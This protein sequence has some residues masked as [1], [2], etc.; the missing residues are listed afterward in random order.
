VGGWGL[1]TGPTK[2]SALA[3]IVVTRPVGREAELV[4][5]LR[6]LGHD[7]V[8]VPLVAIEP[9]GNEPVDVEAYDWVVVTSVVGARELRRR[10][11]G[12][13]RH[14]AAIGKATAD[15]FGGADLVAAP[16]TQ[17]GLL[18]AMPSPAGRVLFAGAERARRLLPD[19]LGAEV[20]ALYRTVELEPCAWPDCDLVVL[21]SA[22]AAR[23][24]GRIDTAA[25]AVSIGPETTRAAVAAGTRIVGE[26]ETSDLA[27]LVAVV[28]HALRAS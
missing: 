6:A 3:R 21:A 16:S 17:E 8:H 2:E 26:A 5:R 12:V 18:A 27:G 22:S 19:A 10:M 14:V 7:V 23:A 28:E 13:P 11:R 9:L 25:P 4:A 24:Y 20:V 1:G 15:A